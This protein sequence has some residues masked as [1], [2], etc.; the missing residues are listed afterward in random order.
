MIPKPNWE[1]ENEL[2]ESLGFN[3]IPDEFRGGKN[4]GWSLFAIGDWR[5]WSIVSTLRGKYINAWQ[6]ARLDADGCYREHYTRRHLKS[7]E[8]GIRGPGFGELKDAL[9]YAKMKESK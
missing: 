6:V 3:C 7:G 1:I 8:Y 5:V 2:A 9:V 4:T